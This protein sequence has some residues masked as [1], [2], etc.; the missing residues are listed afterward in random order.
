MLPPHSVDSSRTLYLLLL[1]RSQIHAHRLALHA[2]DPLFSGFFAVVFFFLLFLLLF[3]LHIFLTCYCLSRYLSFSPSRYLV[4]S[5][6][7]PL[8]HRKEAFL[9]ISTIPPRDR[10]EYSFFHPSSASLFFAPNFFDVS[11]SDVSSLASVFEL[12]RSK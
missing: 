6:L 9:T 8:P 4:A 11:T 3:L 7:C 10:P 5:L 1:D 12:Y 2:R